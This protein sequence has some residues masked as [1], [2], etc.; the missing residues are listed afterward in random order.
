MKN[1]IKRILVWVILPLTTI[2]CVAIA[3]QVNENRSDIEYL[4]VN[5]ENH[6]HFQVTE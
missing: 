5:A 1:W 3:W 4:D 2:A 6:Q